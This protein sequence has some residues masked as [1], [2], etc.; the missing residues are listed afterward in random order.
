MNLNATLEECPDSKAKLAFDLYV[1]PLGDYNGI[2]FMYKSINSNIYK[3][4]SNDFNK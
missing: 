1:H 3:S 2:D 4:I